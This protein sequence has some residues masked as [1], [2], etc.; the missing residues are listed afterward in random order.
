M[1]CSGSKC[2]AYTVRNVGIGQACFC[3]DIE[4][5]K[6]IFCRGYVTWKEMSDYCICCCEQGGRASYQ[7]A[8]ASKDN[9]HLLDMFRIAMVKAECI[10]KA[11]GGISAL[12]GYGQL[13]ALTILPI[14]KEPLV[15]MKRRLGRPHS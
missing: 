7:G 2:Q 6:C 15:P 4:R 14:V 9:E 5:V 13:Y 3:G 11:Y 1:L 12:I 10:M 8:Y